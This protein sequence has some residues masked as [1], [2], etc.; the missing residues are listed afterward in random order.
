ML[1]EIYLGYL[2]VQVDIDGKPSQKHIDPINFFSRIS[3]VPGASYV[4][5]H[6]GYV[7]KIAKN[8]PPLQETMHVFRI[9]NVVLT[10][11]IAKADDAIQSDKARITVC[12]DGTKEESQ[13]L[14]EKIKREFKDLLPEKYNLRK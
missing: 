10:Y 11:D 13:N 14:E 12:L 7:K 4:N 6:Y 5:S 8:C 1:K 3:R 9:N 2:P